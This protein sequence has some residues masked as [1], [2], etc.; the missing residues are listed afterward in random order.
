MDGPSKLQFMNVGRCDVSCRWMHLQEILRVSLCSRLQA[1]DWAF[2][3]RS[4]AAIH[5]SFNGS[6]RLFN[7]ARRT[8]CVSVASISA[9]LTAFAWQ[10]RSP[11]SVNLPVLRWPISRPRAA[12]CT[13][14][15]PKASTSA[16]PSRAGTG[17]GWEEERDGIGWTRRRL[18]RRRHPTLPVPILRPRFY[19]VYLPVRGNCS[20][21]TPLSSTSPRPPTYV[22]SP[23][24]RLSLTARIG[25]RRP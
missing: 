23:S 12:A 25:C 9:N 17:A 2:I 3:R 10:E 15:G 19:L 1:C 6:G 21:A 4:V 13:F 18:R 11:A 22:S 24:L 20:H 5:V 14:S 8:S 7:I 16:Q